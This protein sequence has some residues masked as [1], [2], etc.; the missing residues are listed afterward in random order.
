MATERKAVVVYHD[1]A[2]KGEHASLQELNRLLNDGWL[3][4]S[5]TA[6]GGAGAGSDATGGEMG[7]A[8][9]VILERQK[10]YSVSG[11]GN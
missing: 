11:F 1:P 10:D 8:A 3:P 6:M 9:L 2:E 4:I 5:A 7:Y